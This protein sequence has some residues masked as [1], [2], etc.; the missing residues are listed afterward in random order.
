MTDYAIARSGGFANAAELA[1]DELFVK[2]RAQDGCPASGEI[3]TVDRRNGKQPRRR[4]R[5]G[6]TT[7]REPSVV[8]IPKDIQ[9]VAVK[10]CG[11]HKKVPRAVLETEPLEFVFVIL[12][13]RALVVG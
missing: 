8:N 4:H 7:K 13:H 12:D 11:G 10:C 1:D 3:T 9:R 6:I 5:R 2:V